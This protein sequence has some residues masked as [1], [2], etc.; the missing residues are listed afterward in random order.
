MYQKARQEMQSTMRP[1]IDFMSDIAEQKKESESEEDVPLEVE[2]KKADPVDAD[3][4]ETVQTS[5]AAPDAEEEEESEGPET[6]HI[7]YER[8]VEKVEEIKELLDITTNKEVG[9]KTF[10]YYYE[11]EVE[12]Y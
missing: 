12:E 7:S 11:F 9:E 6:T 10:D 1:I 8:P 5:F 4:L 2:V 3:E